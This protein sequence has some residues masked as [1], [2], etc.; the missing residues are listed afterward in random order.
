MKGYF[1]HMHSMKIQ[2]YSIIFRKYLLKYRF[3]KYWTNNSQAKGS[4]E[5]CSH[6]FSIFRDGEDC[7]ANHYL[8]HFFF[9]TPITKE[10]QSKVAKIKE[11]Y[12]GNGNDINDLEVLQNLTNTFTDSG[13]FYGTDKMAR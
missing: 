12:F 13:F 5:C 3:C 7:A 1:G 6:F 11:E 8:G 2:I 9:G 10:I 4:Q